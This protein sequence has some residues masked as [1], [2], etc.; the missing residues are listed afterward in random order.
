[1]TG[2]ASQQIEADTTPY[3]VV[4]QTGDL[5]NPSVRRIP[6]EGGQEAVTTYDSL[7]RSWEYDDRLISIHIEDAHGRSF[8][9]SAEHSE[10]GTRY[11]LPLVEVASE[12]SDADIDEWYAREEER[13]DGIHKDSLFW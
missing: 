5:A 1:M 10:F 7:K 9:P 13:M 3:V 2:G 4:E 11:S 6:V 8:H 12:P